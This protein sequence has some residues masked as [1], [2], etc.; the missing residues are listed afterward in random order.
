MTRE[1]ITAWIT[2]YALTDGITAH[3][4]DVCLGIDAQMFVSSDRLVH[5]YCEDWH[6]TPEGALARAEKMRLAKIASLKRQIDKLE[7]MIFEVPGADK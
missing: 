4:G 5:A 1:K 6:L 3:E 2:R 7:R